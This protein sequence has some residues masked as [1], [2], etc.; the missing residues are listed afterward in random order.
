LDIFIV[1]RT[2]G[3]LIRHRYDVVYAHE[4][5]V[6]FCRYLKPIFRFKL[7]YDMHSSLTQQLE[8]F[9]YTNSRI[10]HYI[11][12]KLE[13]SSINAAD[14]VIT[15]CPDLAD[16]VSRIIADPSKHY[17]IE[18]AEELAVYNWGVELYSDYYFKQNHRGLF[19]GL[20]LSLNGFRFNDIPNP[21]TILALYAVPRIG[22]RIYLPKKLKA[23]YFQPSLTVPFKVWDNE[24]KF[25]YR[26]ID[27]KSIF[28]ISQ[29]TLG[30][31]I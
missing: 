24:E 9:N 18:N 10:V 1:A 6:F 5:A 17:L 15:I 27:T 19:L 20:L 7:V 22:Y 12:K 26:E 14:A 21:Q 3:L 31:K 13:A 16:H 4:E 11:F 29:L 30:M 23:F 28:L 2:I 8:N 25:L